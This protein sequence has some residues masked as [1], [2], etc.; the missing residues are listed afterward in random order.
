MIVTDFYLALIVGITL[1]LIVSERFGVNPGGLI[2]PGY[3]ALVVETPEVLVAT[4][5]ISFL[6]F[7]IVKYI[8]PKIMIVYGRRRFVAHLILAVVIKLI[9]DFAFPVLTFGI[10]ELRGLGV[11]MPALM[12]NCYHK[13]GVNLTLISMVAVT[14]A[15][16]AIL[17]L[18]YMIM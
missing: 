15:T 11:I 1:S 17:A 14:L 5:L 7:G 12:A 2:V 4:L 9:L 16:Y 3:L 18:S 13:Q 10:F 6:V 8:L